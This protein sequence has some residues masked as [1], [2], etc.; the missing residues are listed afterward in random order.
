MFYVLR[1]YFDTDRMP[2]MRIFRSLAI[3]AIPRARFDSTAVWWC[4]EPLNLVNM[5]PPGANNSSPHEAVRTRTLTR[6]Y[7][8]A[9]SHRISLTQTTTHTR[10][11]GAFAFFHFNFV[12]SM[13]SVMNMDAFGAFPECFFFCRLWGSQ[14]INVVRRASLL[15]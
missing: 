3:V 5:P 10:R 12:F 14:R 2:L 7:A 8:H 11:G 13:M 6:L 4:R 9:Y 1:V 15:R